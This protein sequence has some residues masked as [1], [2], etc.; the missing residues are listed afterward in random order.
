MSLRRTI[1]AVSLS[2]FAL[3][4]LAACGEE[5]NGRETAPPPT[6]S[7]QAAAIPTAEDL[8]LLLEQASDP[9]VPVEEK[10]NLV[11][12]GAEAPEIF[13]QIA[14]LKAR[15]ASR[16]EVPEELVAN[17]RRIAE[18]SARAEGKP[19]Q[20]IQKIVDGK[21]NAYFKDVVLT[22]QPSVQDSKKTVGDQLSAA[23]VRVTRFARFE[24]GQS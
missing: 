22:E 14:A 24:V 5:E 6:T 18:E 2:A 13:D 12:G 19:E 17:E 23:G 9:A 10:V 15:Y 11:E 1:A 7:A 16:D 8:S 21:V 3:A 20:A 4:G